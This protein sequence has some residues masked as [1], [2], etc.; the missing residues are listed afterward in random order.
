MAR[1]K[2]RQATK[3]DVPILLSLLYDLGRPKPKN[4]SDVD[5]FRKMVRKYLSDSDKEILVAEKDDIE[6]VGMVGMV[7]LPRL[8]QKKL[9]MYIPELVVSEKHRNGGIGGKLINECIEMAKKK[10]C[11]RIRL[12]S[13][14]QRTESHEFYKKLGFE[15]NALSFSKELKSL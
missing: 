4:D 1:M 6:I 13:G 5:E 9:E 12:E 14:N 10:N 8:N 2:I 15:Q 7:F 11:H 3:K